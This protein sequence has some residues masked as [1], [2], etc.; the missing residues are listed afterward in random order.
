MIERPPLIVIVHENAQTLGALE[1]LLARRDYQ[2][3]TFTRPVRA[4]DFIRRSRAELI[5][6]EQP[7]VKA[8]GIDFLEQIK[9]VSSSS[10]CVFL[11]SPIDLE[12]DGRTIRRVQAEG[13]L[14][15]VDRLLLSLSIPDTRRYTIAPGTAPGAVKA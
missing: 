11:P 10:E 5:L 2:V 8:D 9:M 12:M 14:K 15:I 4:L 3:A 6:A 7:S 13:I 1:A